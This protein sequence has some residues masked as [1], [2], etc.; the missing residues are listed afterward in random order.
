MTDRADRRICLIV[1]P[2][3]GRVKREPDALSAIR[4]ALGAGAAERS[5]SKDGSIEDAARTACDEGFD[6]V[7]PVGGDGTIM[8]V[9]GV[10]AGTGTALGVLPMGTFN[11]FARGLGIPDD[12][13]EAARLL[14][15]GA[16]RTISVGEVNGRI[17]LNNA[18]LGVYPR[19]L[20]VREGVYRRFGRH[21]I[22]AYWSVIKTF[23]RF[24][25]P[26]RLAIDAEGETS[27]LRTPLLFVA[28]SA[29]QLEE[30]GLDGSDYVHDDAFAVFAAPAGSRRDLFV[31]AWRLVRG[32]M[33]SGQDYTLR[34]HADFTVST[35]RR[36]A[37]VACDGEKFLM[38]TPL[39]FRMRPDALRVIVPSEPA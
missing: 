6:V 33:K 34:G 21:R 4:A 23:A 32:T 9:A 20:R 18:S 5:V 26:L 31:E 11:Y 29:F 13:G 17:F 1:N 27:R 14:T 25:R 8:T 16:A 38:Q 37:L 12:P 3:S 39:R 35:A 24:Q 10:L 7:V 19:I 15:S 28:R 2:G 22:A 30:Y 36:R